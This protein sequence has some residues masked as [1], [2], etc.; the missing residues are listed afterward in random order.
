MFVSIVELPF[1]GFDNNFFGFVVST[2][3]FFGVDFFLF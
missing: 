1:S 3:I 2:K